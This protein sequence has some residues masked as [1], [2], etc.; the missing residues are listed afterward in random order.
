MD[1]S[2]VPQTFPRALLCSDRGR[3]GTPALS[4][5]LD[6]LGGPFFSTKWEIPNPSYEWRNNIYYKFKQDR[7]EC[8]SRIRHSTTIKNEAGKAE[9]SSSQTRENS[10]VNSQSHQENEN[11]IWKGQSKNRTNSEAPNL[12]CIVA[13]KALVYIRCYSS[14]IKETN[15]LKSWLRT[16]CQVSQFNNG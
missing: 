16:N 4:K 15:L 14:C 6:A 11:P 1:G 9:T 8:L 13:G 2:S 5:S 3:I 10:Q 7:R 12:A